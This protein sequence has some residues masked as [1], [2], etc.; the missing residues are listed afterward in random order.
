MQPSTDLDLVRRIQQGESSAFA[1]LYYR[2]KRHI[3]EYCFRL[4]QEKDNAD[5]ALQ[6]TFIKVYQNVGELKNPASFKAWLFTIARNEVYTV[7]RRTRTN[8]SLD[9]E[10][11]FDPSSPHEEVVAQEQTALVQKFLAQLKPTYREVLILLE[12]EQLSYAEIA[13]VTGV[14]VSSVESM[15]FRA[16]KALAKKLKPYY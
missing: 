14:S 10:D 9:D 8:G 16:R 11:V 13:S 3:Y 4:L 6:N 5:D 12:Y 2:Y 1:E 15:I 7:F